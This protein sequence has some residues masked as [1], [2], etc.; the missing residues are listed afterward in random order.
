[1]RQKRIK[2]GIAL[3]IVPLILVGCG[4]N[5]NDSNKSVEEELTGTEEQRVAKVEEYLLKNAATVW[6]EEY[7]HGTTICYRAAQKPGVTLPGKIEDPHFLFRSVDPFRHDG[8]VYFVSFRVPVADV[9]KWATFL[10]SEELRREKGEVEI[11]ESAQR[12]WWGAPAR[13]SRLTFYKPR[14]LSGR[15][16]GWTGVDR[17]TGDIFIYSFT[18]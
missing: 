15:V 11:L 4:V 3:A 6:R 13:L 14:K 7:R 1:M 16:N 8:D 9:D 12:D 5:P 17:A 2:F 10:E 18:M